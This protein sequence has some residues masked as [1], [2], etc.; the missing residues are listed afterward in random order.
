M[1][2]L[3]RRIPLFVLSVSLLAPRALAQDAKK[4]ITVDDLWTLQ[5][6]GAPILSPDGSLTV[7]T[8]TIPDPKANTTDSDLWI[9]RT[10]GGTPPRRLTWNVGP[11]G[12]PS[13]SPD[14]RTIAYVSKRGSSPGQLYLLPLA[15]GEAERVTDLP[16]AVE[17]PK[18]FPDGK[19][20]A[21]VASTW[22]DLND[23]FD[24]VKKRLDEADKDDVKARVSEN[25]LWRFWDHPL[26]D[27]R[28]PHLFRV[29]LKTRKVTDLMPRSA[30][31]MGLMEI[32][33]GYDISPDGKEVMFSANSSSPPYR[34]LNYDLFTVSLAGEPMQNLT[35]GNPADDTR[36][37]YTPDGK[38]AVYG[39]QSRPDTD[40]DFVHLMRVDLR[41]GKTIEL[42]K[43]FDATVSGWTISADGLV[44]FHAES[45]G[46][47]N[48]YA[49][50]LAGGPP[51]LV[52]HG[53]VTGSVAV[54]R[55]GTL[56]FTKES[57][58]SPPEIWTA[59]ASG[60]G[61]KPL[62]SFNAAKMATLELGEVKNV[63]FK[64]AGGDEVQMF[65]VCPPGFS[66]TD[67]A[68]WPMVQLIHGGPFG[69]WTDG[70]SYR[71]NPMLFA[72]RGYVSV[73]VN[74]HGSSG[75]GQAFADSI[76]GA[77]GD[78]PFADIMMATDAVVSHGGIDETRLA[79]GGGSYGG[80]LTAWILGHTDR[81][82]ALFVH[83]GPF[84]LIG[85][86]ASDMTYGRSKNYG[87]A[88]WTDPARIDASSP[89]HYASAF[90]TPT[91]VLHGEKDYRVPYSQGA[92]LYGVL[93]AKGVPARLVVFPDENH[94]ILKAKSS[95][96][97]YGEVLGWLDRWLGKA[98]SGS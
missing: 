36:P 95:T 55:R 35:P 57:M 47:V 16:V 17:D 41:S 88:P 82:K 66:E 61:L 7:F 51:R 13:F 96:L 12:S 91:L 94:W 40:S 26:T 74:F 62:T 3:F 90:K 37:R 69:S 93:T 68:R 8:V 28:Y 56:V 31:Y 77:P 71:W 54:T 48:L 78:K 33:G 23:D 1:E 22:P 98:P 64:G 21:F 27:G 34:T 70:W 58:T 52:V 92:D 72:A 49:V 53:G 24:A 29:D 15:G 63:T 9:A 65:I 60:D 10:D 46:K 32:G 83:S 11:D 44:Y 38:Y 97:W 59:R 89:S 73:L 6:V 85:Q 67:P 43:P 84:D 19:G 79:A 30:R 87:A 25:R 2:P 50:P 80:Y 18:W 4:G 20:I 39:K 45:R 81:F 86:F 14:G 42:A 75:A 5:R 76:E